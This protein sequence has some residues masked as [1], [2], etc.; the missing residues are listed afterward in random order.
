LSR[1]EYEPTLNTTI[2]KLR[3]KETVYS[4]QPKTSHATEKINEIKTHEI[5]TTP[6]IQYME[7]R[8]SEL[9]CQIGKRMSYL[10]TMTLTINYE[11]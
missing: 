6:E 4:I 7:S 1:R 8:N 2:K 5:S 9:I 10:L 11:L 3:L